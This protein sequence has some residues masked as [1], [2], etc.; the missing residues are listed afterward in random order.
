MEIACQ[1]VPG[2]WVLDTVDGETRVGDKAHYVVAIFINQGSRF[3]VIARQKH[4][5]A[6]THTEHGL[7]LVERLGG[8]HHRL[9]QQELE[10]IW[11]Y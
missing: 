1:L 6:A 3:L 10:Q 7:M 8:E 5:A 2:L 11:Q 4:L 9:L